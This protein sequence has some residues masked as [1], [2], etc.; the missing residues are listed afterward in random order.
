MTKYDLHTTVTIAKALADPTRLRLLNA[1]NGCELCV[2]QLQALVELAPSSISEHLAQLRRAGLVSS[3]KQGRWVY[4]KATEQGADVQVDG[5]L[6]W[7]SASL[8]RAPELKADARRLREILRTP[9]EE[10]CKL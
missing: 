4:Y 3:R 1:L 2:C 9:P 8:E 6:A 5:L 7:L 10:L